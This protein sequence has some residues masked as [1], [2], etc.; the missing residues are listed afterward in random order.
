MLAGSDRSMLPVE[1]PCLMDQKAKTISSQLRYTC[2]HTSLTVCSRLHPQQQHESMIYLKAL[3]QGGCWDGAG[4]E[5]GGSGRGNSSCGGQ[6][7]S[8]SHQPHR[9]K[10]GKPHNCKSRHSAWQ[11]S[12]FQS[13]ILELC[14]SFPKAE[15]KAAIHRFLR[16][17]LY[18]G[19]KLLAAT[20][21]EYALIGVLA[22]V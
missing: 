16:G 8:R 12:Y 10:P 14:P 22:R 13:A 17:L 2:V 20:P 21:A 9:Y 5:V 18:I 7:L 15:K 19:S 11:N 1:Y 4:S 3:C 6:H